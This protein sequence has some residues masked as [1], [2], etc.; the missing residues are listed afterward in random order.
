MSIRTVRN[1]NSFREGK[2]GAIQYHKNIIAERN[3]EIFALKQRLRAADQ[4]IL[5]LQDR[6][7]EA[8]KA[9]DISRAIVVCLSA[10]GSNVDKEKS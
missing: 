2:I 10:N 9:L 7:I 6:C 3:K 4:H 8:E 1:E 5:V